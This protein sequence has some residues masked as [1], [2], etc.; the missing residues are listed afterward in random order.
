MKPREFFRKWKEGIDNV[1]PKQQAKGKLIGI[2]GSIVGLLLAWAVMTIR[3]LWYFGIV[4]FFAIWMQVIAYIGTKQ[5]YKTIVESEESQ[6]VNSF[7]E[8]GIDEKE[9]FGG[10]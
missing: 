9:L 2:K 6:T 4:M 5:Q 10:K 7:T 3:G 8:M 1:T